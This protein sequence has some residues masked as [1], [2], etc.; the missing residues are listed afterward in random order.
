MNKVLTLPVGQVWVPGTIDKEK[1]KEIEEAKIE[2]IR[3]ASQGSS[4]TCLHYYEEI[5]L[6][7][8]SGHWCKKCGQKRSY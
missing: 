8:T 4:A 3:Q 1:R 2:G 6:F 5:I 7:T